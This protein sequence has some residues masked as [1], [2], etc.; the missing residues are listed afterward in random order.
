LIAKNLDPPAP[1]PLA[2]NQDALKP[3]IP[4]IYER[5]AAILSSNQ[6]DWVLRLCSSTRFLNAFRE[7]LQ[8]R[9]LTGHDVQPSLSQAE[10]CRNARKIN[11][12]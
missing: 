2:S 10:E 8:L 11:A 12:G 5:R 4:P 1:D 7:A 6:P 3:R 9:V